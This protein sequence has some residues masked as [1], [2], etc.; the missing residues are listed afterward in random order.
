MSPAKIS[1]VT[2]SL[3][4]AVYL[5]ECLHSV[6]T[7]GILD[8]EH[9][10]VDGGSKDRSIE[11][12]AGFAERCP[13]KFNW[14]SESDLGQSD[15]LNKGFLK[16]EGE[17][18]GWLNADDRYRPG[19]LES[20]QQV[21]R[22]YPN[23]DVVY[24]DYTWIDSDGATI[25]QRREISFSPFVL[26]YHRVLYI[27]TAAVFFRRRVID[28]GNLLD[29]TLHYAMD[30]EFFVRL[31]AQGYRFQHLSKFLGDFRF[32]PDSKTSL[33]PRKQLHET[34]AVMRQYSPILRHHS[35]GMFAGALTF[36]L[37]TTAGIRRYSEK[38]LRGYY[39]TQFRSTTPHR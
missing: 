20:V 17:I 33:Q 12:L 35:A 28:D 4:Q 9:I 38:A 36:G 3:N 13:Y 22:S 23:V 2:P 26:L 29:E 8:V 32:Q 6:M 27:Q 19:A 1:I 25:Q 14:K 31:S 5:D 24:G 37:R 11:I 15:A 39:L 7:Q 30:F 18:I 21:F 10:V 16:A 34:T